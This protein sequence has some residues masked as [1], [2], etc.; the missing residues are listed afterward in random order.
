[1]FNWLKKV[2]SKKSVIVFNTISE[3]TREGINKAYIPKFLY[4][5]PYG[6][7]RFANMGYIRYLAQ[8]PYVE[9]CIQTIIDEIIAIEWDIIPIEGMEEY[10]DDSEIQHMK[11]FFLNP[12][13]NPN[14]HFEDVFVKMP[15]RDILEVNTAVLNK[16]FNLKEELVE[17]VARDAATFTVN[18]DIHG[19]F[20]HRDDIILSNTI[21]QNTEFQ[22]QIEENPNEVI[23]P[24]QMI[25]AHNARERA[26]Y[27]QYGWISGPVPTPFGKREIIWMQKMKRTDDHYGFSAVQILAK[28]LQ[29]LLYMVES[30]LEYY[31][32]NN[33]P[34]G[35]IGI[36][37]A[38]ADEIEAF[39][40]QWH[41]IQRKKD[42]FGNWKKDFNKVPIVN[43]IPKF[44][45]IQFSSQ[46][47]QLIEK[48]RWY[49]K[50][51][52][53]CFGVTAVE[54]G[55]TEDA[56]GSANQI[57]QSKVF[58]KKAINPM[59]RLLESS[60]NHSII[61][62]FEYT[63]KVK[64]GNKEMDMPK[65]KFVFKKFDVD[66]EMAKAELYEKW[67]DNSLYTL[68]EIRTREGKEDLD[69]GDRPPSEWKKSANSFDFSG[70]NP[71]NPE[72][73]QDPGKDNKKFSDREKDALNPKKPQED[74]EDKSHI[75]T[76][77]PGMGYGPEKKNPLIV[78]EGEKPTNWA[79]LS[80]AIKHVLKLNEEQLLLIIRKETGNVEIKS[81][82]DIAEQIK[83]I[84]SFAGLKSIL[85]EIIRNNFHEGH[86]DS[87]EEIGRNFIP[88]QEAIDFISEYTF[89]NIQDINEDLADSLRKELK[90]SFMNGEG[91]DKITERVQRVFGV[92]ENRAEAIARTESNRA[93]N[94]GR[95]QAY[96]KN[97][98]EAK[99]WLDWTNDHRT[100]PLTVA[101]HVKYGNPSK[102]IPLDENFTATA[103]VGK[104]TVSVDQG[105][106]PFH[107]GER[108]VLMFLPIEEKE[109]ENSEFKL[110]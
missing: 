12:N 110:E 35:I 42:E 72:T 48:Q 37:G 54:L 34:K 3:E 36:D 62:E 96:T 44:E 50:M 49:S 47:M 29:M 27:F 20:T 75:E 102:A 82:N 58:R 89:E 13:T 21:I 80:D 66:E 95:L 60:Y 33:V 109:E 24:F 97:G 55:Y 64:V 46:E 93:Y 52:W 57:V 5:P 26:A 106:P 51:V 92:S 84:L 41:D 18:P 61:D 14:E 108:D 32:D 25:P 1:M 53:A 8:T 69:W 81:I 6:Y 38:D 59:L 22:K 45:T 77:P 15:V 16:V 88:D 31:N 99:K 86:E 17:I 11:N 83:K 105:A 4:K 23:N 73:P 90:Q 103:V 101:L 63:H 100:S 70:Q 98:I 67:I 94:Q 68:N 39:K 9:M 56:K 2:I 74:I 91:I 10:K 71:G 104:K 79:R 28:S 30:D 19:M 78:E 107:I 85:D 7:P 76:K 40:E 65:Y 87:E 43:K